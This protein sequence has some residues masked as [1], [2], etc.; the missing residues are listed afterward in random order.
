MAL[1]NNVCMICG[2]ASVFKIY[3]RFPGYVQG[4]YFDIFKC[5]TCDTQFIST[6][7]MLS[8][9]YDFIYSQD[10]SGYDRYHKYA[11]IIKQQLSPLKFLAKKEAD[12]YAVYE[13]LRGSN[14]TKT[15]LEVG[16]GLGY[17]T[18]SLQKSNY[19]AL[20]IDIS[21]TAIDFAERQFGSYY[22]NIDLKD[23]D[24]KEKFDLIVA[25]ELIEHL[26]NPLEFLE[27]CKKHLKTNGAILLTTP[28]YNHK[29][30]IWNTDLPP[31]HV[32]WLSKKSFAALA[33]SCDLDLS[34]VNFNR[35]VS[36]NDLLAFLPRISLPGS[37]L[38]KKLK[39]VQ[40]EATF[41]SPLRQIATGFAYCT[42][43]RYISH[44]IYRL[45]SAEYP[46]LGVI[47]T[48]K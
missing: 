44:Y 41:N 2:S 7:N 37:I 4:T 47:L 22:L 24:I 11:K 8:E 18:Y 28:N 26:K 38:D 31:V 1:K 35:F 10:V 42:P 43:M 20:G 29:N 15:I 27:C 34:F 19:Q 5:S 16:C 25:T 46:L 40:T 17:L 23:L 39:S 13:Y 36:K 12:Y 45:I 9:I 3:S 48:E 33:K 21:K 30:Q 6:D 32:F 14:N